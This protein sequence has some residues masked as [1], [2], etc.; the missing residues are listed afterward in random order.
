MSRLDAERHSILSGGWS[1]EARDPEVAKPNLP[2][3]NEMVFTSIISFVNGG[4]YEKAQY[5]LPS[6]WP[7]F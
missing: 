3:T 6:V 4:L 1:A 7:Q 2:A 5:R